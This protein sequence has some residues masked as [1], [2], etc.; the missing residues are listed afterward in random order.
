V[1]QGIGDVKYGDQNTDGSRSI[2][3]FYDPFRHAGASARAMPD[4]PRH[5]FA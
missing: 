1:E 5:R 2:R 4:V 3:D